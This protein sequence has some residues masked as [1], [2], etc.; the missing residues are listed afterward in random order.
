MKRFIL[1][2][3]PTVLVIIIIF[4]FLKIFVIGDTGKGAL[5]VT[6]HP[7]SK[8]YIDDAYIGNTPLCRCE[9]STMLK[10]G[11]YTIRI[12]PLENSL[13]EFREKIT[14]TK[15]V[16]T[17][18]DR[19][20]GKGATSEG[21]VVSL[22][23]LA[24]KKATELLVISFPDKADLF[25]DG[26][27]NGQTAVSVKNLTDS[28]HTLLLKKDGYKDKSVRIRTP[29]GY[30]LVATVYLAL[31]DGSEPTGTPIPS[32]SP[33]ASIT[34]TP[35]TTSK[36][37]ILQTPNGFLRVRQEA[38]LNSPEI[39][40]VTPGETYKVLDEVSGWYQ[41]TLTDGSTGWVSSQFAS[42]Q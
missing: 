14:I 40:R 13:P 17:V 15:G 25:V 16:L 32:A 41:I 36:I 11:D 33:A 18:V 22:V 30:K 38:S 9:T 19:K 29:L 39:G 3:I 23:P 4:G 10:N 20:F 1:F 26:A 21:S 28:D 12:V 34:P 42:K 31:L 5:Q 8:V 27:N 24:N 35:Q 2:F 7:L 6:S 37:T